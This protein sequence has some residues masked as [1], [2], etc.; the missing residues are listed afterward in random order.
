MEYSYVLK[1]FY[2]VMKLHCKTG[3][4]KPS[5]KLTLESDDYLTSFPNSEHK[6]MDSNSDSKLKI[7]QLNQLP[8]LPF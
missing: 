3:S 1:T 6:S 7:Q 8:L 5:S 2:P 4:S